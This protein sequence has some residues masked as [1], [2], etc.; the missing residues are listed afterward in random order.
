MIL[1]GCNNNVSYY[2]FVAYIEDSTGL[3]NGEYVDLN[4]T[5]S[6]EEDGVFNLFSK[7]M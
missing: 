1:N 5:V 2:P 4:M 7:A 3:R 6:D